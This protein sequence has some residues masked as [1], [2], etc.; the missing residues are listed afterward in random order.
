[1]GT[2]Y[3]ARDWQSLGPKI[4]VELCG[5]ARSFPHGG[6]FPNWNVRLS[7][8]LA[9][10]VIPISMSA[11][12]QPARVLEI[13]NLGKGV[14]V[15]DGPWQFH[16]GD[17]PSFAA[18]DLDDATGHN[19]WE[20]INTDAPWGTQGHRSYSGYAWYRKRLAITP[21]PSTSPD[22][23]LLLPRVADVYAVYWNGALVGIRGKF[24][25]NPE[26]RWSR[27][28]E[29]LPIRGVEQGVLAVRVYK[30]PLTSYENGLQGGL[31]APPLLGS[32]RTIQLEQ[33]A[34]DYAWLRG[35]QFSFAVACLEVLVML[36]ALIKWWRDRSQRVL[37]ATFLF[38]FALVGVFAIVN[39]HLPLSFDFAQGVFE[40]LQ[41]I[42]DVSLMYLL[43]W[44]LDLYN[45]PTLQRWTRVA[46]IV[47]VVAHVADGSTCLLDWSNPHL[48]LFCQWFDASCTLIFTLTELWPVILVCFGIRRHL[49]LPRWLVSAFAFLVQ[50]SFVI[51]ATLSQGSRFTHWTLGYTL[52]SPLFTIAGNSF[53]IQT[54]FQFGL[55]IG[56]IF[57]IFAYSRDTLARKQAI[58]QELRSA[59][60][61]MQVIIPEA[62][63]SL[64]GYALT[65]SYQ[66]AQELG[67]DFF[68]IIPVKNGSYVIA[69]GD[70]SGKGLR[71]A[72]AVA[73]IVGSLRTLAEIDS[74]P[75]TILAGLNHRLHNRLQ[76]G[77]A[78][79]VVILLNVH[80]QCTIANAGHPA[81]FL[82]GSEVQLA[83]SLPL[84]ITESADYGELQLEMQVEDFLLLYSDG[85]LEARNAEG[86]LFGFERLASLVADR[87]TAIQALDAASAF[88][89]EDD[90]T[91][92]TLTRITS[93]EIPTAELI[94]PVLAP[95]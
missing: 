21:A 62:L 52:G 17:D 10:L 63:P 66:P 18:L 60:E 8:F 87:P 45:N 28:S 81:P 83:G 6:L 20:Q 74:S 57:A 37:L 12:A 78:T 80:G 24:P 92:L 72:M 33:T 68:Q 61:L 3:R 95:T 5:M 7:L 69:L 59:Q 65:S 22:W 36:L 19:G 32:P 2:C 64:P 40:L 30:Y 13:Q 88:G 25:P 90:I 54:L 35:N 26:W 67:G 51:P 94:A 91:I 55:L 14:V 4:E 31:Y 71:A 9:L 29:F 58:E 86:E 84:G 56:V 1:L 79:C 48:T 43:L 77:F 73:L 50:L 89:Q 11:T 41:A 39:M 15:L 49:D 82:N 70:V 85:L 44:L 76:G 16:L 27:T 46:A 93:G 75:S 47:N 53:A 38:C 34:E 42:E 23:S